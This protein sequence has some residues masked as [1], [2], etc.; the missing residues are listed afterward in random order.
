V[1]RKIQ[2]KPAAPAGGHFDPIDALTKGVKGLFNP[3][4]AKPTGPSAATKPAG[5]PWEVEGQDRPERLRHTDA[6][7]ARLQ[8]LVDSG[9]LSR[10]QASRAYQAA[11]KRTPRNQAEV[12]R[13]W[14]QVDSGQLTR[15]Q[16]S[17]AY[18]N[19]KNPPFPED[20]KTPIARRPPPPTGP[21]DGSGVAGRVELAPKTEKE[22][23]A[24]AAKRGWDAKEIHKRRREVAGL[25]P[26]T[27]L[28]PEKASR[29][30]E[31]YRA[32]DTP[33]GRVHDPKL[34][35]GYDS[36][37]KPRA[38]GGSGV[39]WKGWREGRPNPTPTWSTPKNLGA[40]AEAKGKV[41]F[42]TKYGTVWRKP[43]NPPGSVPKGF[44]KSQVP[45]SRG[46]FNIKPDPAT[47]RDAYA[48]A[49]PKPKPKPQP[50]PKPKPKGVF[51]RGPGAA[52]PR[53]L[54][55]KKV[56]PPD[57]V[58]K[59][60]TQPAAKPKTPPSNQSYKG[61]H[62][63]GTTNLPKPKTPAPPAMSRKAG[64]SGPSPQLSGPAGAPG[65]EE[66]F[67][68]TAMRYLKKNKIKK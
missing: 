7:V 27:K 11:V 1:T 63:S 5:A 29:D 61:K 68:A 3:K 25:D 31:A 41:P 9:K 60:A 14:K 51:K 56:D 12:D 64:S 20:P 13:L 46:Y 15:K 10:Q 43:S 18:K 33:S 28:P 30:P 49:H 39:P 66:G 38:E 24:L 65:D 26:R 36:G 17:A 34:T 21:R 59:P 57:Q 8:K 35:S 58:L 23:A 32:A 44:A 42:K 67:N 4:P 52:G 40:Q 47:Y 62:T 2:G 45:A 37:L 6:E 22:V 54:Q 19:F 48:D 55:Y 16:A 50:K 53:Q